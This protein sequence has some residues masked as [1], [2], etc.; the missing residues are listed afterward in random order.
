MGIE[1]MRFK[2]IQF[3][4]EWEYTNP[5]T[6]F[7]YKS[8]VIPK[9]LL[10]SSL[11]GIAN[12]TDVDKVKET[13]SD[14]IR[15][16]LLEGIQYIRVTDY[17]GIGKISLAVRKYYAQVIKDLSEKYNCNPKIGYVYGANLG[18]KSI[19]RLFAPFVPCPE[20]YTEITHTGQRF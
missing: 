11:Q 1:K 14:A 12:K 5:E 17:S 20:K 18:M 7:I 4:P 13:L 9:K 19:L 6:G 2:D 16:G 10:Y 8:G 3:K 15:T